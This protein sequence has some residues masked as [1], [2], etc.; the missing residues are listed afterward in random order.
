ML[1]V[2]WYTSTFW[3]KQKKF[4]KLLWLKVYFLDEFPFPWKST[5]KVLWDDEGSSSLFPAVQWN[6]A[7]R[8]LAHW[9]RHASTYSTNIYFIARLRQERH[10]G[11]SPCSPEACHLVWTKNEG[12]AS[13]LSLRQA[14]LGIWPTATSNWLQSVR[15]T[16]SYAAGWSINVHNRLGNNL[17][18]LIKSLHKFMTCA[19]PF[20]TF[21]SK[22]H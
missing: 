15:P 12:R 21:I 22:E 19:F 13:T 7:L 14:L 2:S 16:I 9:L 10:Q 8:F 5:A 18:M 6:F 4:L 3:L 17:A 11:H 20:W 1:S